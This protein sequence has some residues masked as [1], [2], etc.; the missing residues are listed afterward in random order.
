VGQYPA[1]QFQ[2]IAASPDAGDLASQER[3]VTDRPDGA[4]HRAARIE[5]AVRVVVVGSADKRNPGTPH[6]RP[7]PAAKNVRIKPG[8]MSSTAIGKK[9]YIGMRIPC[10]APLQSDGS[11][12][13]HG[14]S[15]AIAPDVICGAQESRESD[16]TLSEPLSVRLIFLSQ[17]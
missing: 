6:P 15:A 8:I 11:R 16:I 9:T 3:F 1:R 13:G 12:P 7:D 10:L 2:C 17:M 5:R 4:E 14:S